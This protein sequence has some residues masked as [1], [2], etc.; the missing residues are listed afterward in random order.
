MTKPLILA[1]FGTAVVSAA[2]IL[3]FV[4]EDTGLQ[5]PMLK[6]ASPP[7]ET[8]TSTDPISRGSALKPD[9]GTK[10]AQTHPSFD[11]VRINSNGDTVM[12]GR[13]SP[14]LL[15][16]IFDGN[17]KIGEVTTD[18]RGEWVFVP[19]APLPAGNRELLL[20]V[21]NPD[22]TKTTS[23]TNV[24]LVVPERGKD[25]AGRSAGQES[26]PL[27]IKI[28]LSD[29]SMLEVLQKPNPEET[30]NS[31]VL[32]VDA[33]DYNDMGLLT[34][35]GKAPISATVQIY[36]N[37][38]FIGRTSSNERGLWNLSPDEVVPPGMYKLRADQVDNNGKVTARREV[39]FA[40]SVPLT[41]VKPGTLV[42]VEPGNSL[43]RIAR[44]TYG[45]GFK[46]TV[47]YQANRDQIKNA[48]L[49]FPGQVFSLPALK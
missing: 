8:S 45:S 44:K 4:F 1:L 10:K 38:K 47:I 33:I 17:N 6:P 27:A 29:S 48:N 23:K 46:F 14:G 21:I 19:S 16:E 9:P 22:G 35:A 11:V 39:V 12:A 7:K 42:V 34:V 18:K 24:L 28:P 41:N 15:V 31:V 20:R 5:E 2:I 30:G 40:R 13:A 37:N 36:L 25:I 49:I 26:R 43:W 3:N 32:T